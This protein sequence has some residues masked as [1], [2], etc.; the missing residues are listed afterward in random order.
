VP[1]ENKIHVTTYSPLLDEY[2]KAATEEFSM[3]YQ[4]TVDK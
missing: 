1:G 3:N 4:M 2:N